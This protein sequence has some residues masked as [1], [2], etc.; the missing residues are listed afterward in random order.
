[1]SA[2]CPVTADDSEDGPREGSSTRIWRLGT[3]HGQKMGALGIQLRARGPRGPPPNRC[4]LVDQETCFHVLS[5]GSK[6][7]V[8]AGRFSQSLPEPPPKSTMVPSAGLKAMACLPRASGATCGD[9][10]VQVLLL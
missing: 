3:S 1:V 5:T 8:A 7:Q 2:G 4:S 6:I 9:S 10:S